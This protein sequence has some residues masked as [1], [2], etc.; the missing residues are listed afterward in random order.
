MAGIPQ[1]ITEDR[2][3]WCSFVEG[4]LKFDSSKNQ[5]LRKTFYC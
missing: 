2:V 3:V 1:V 5:Y 4:S